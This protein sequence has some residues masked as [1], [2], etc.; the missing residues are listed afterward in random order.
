M[1]CLGMVLCVSFELLRG[2]DDGTCAQS[3]G[4]MRIL[5]ITVTCATTS[6]LRAC[7]TA[8]SYP[9]YLKVYCLVHTF[10]FTRRL[11][12]RHFFGYDN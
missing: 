11:T 9:A 1:I 5:I 3:M 10:V 4:R 8:R 6:G 2:G 12:M 7:F